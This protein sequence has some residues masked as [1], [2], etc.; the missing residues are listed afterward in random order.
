M[1]FDSFF[2]FKN[3]FFAEEMYGGKVLACKCE[4]KVWILRNK[5]QLDVQGGPPII[6]VYKKHRQPVSVVS[7]LARAAEKARSKFRDLVLICTVQSNQRRHQISTSNL[8]KTM[9]SFS[10]TH[11]GI[12][13]HTHT[14]TQTHMH[15]HTCSLT[16][17]AYTFSFF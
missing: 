2:A 17:Y 11:Q 13:K 1:D 16:P 7:Q 5:V 12:C 14:E 10:C 15:T 3:Y 4:D 9:N 6:A 8:H